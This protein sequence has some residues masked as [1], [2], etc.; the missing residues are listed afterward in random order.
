MFVCSDEEWKTLRS[1]MTT[2]FTGA[3]MKD[4]FKF[5]DKCARQSIQHLEKQ[6]RNRSGKGKPEGSTKPNVS[7]LIFCF[8]GFQMTQT[9]WNW[10]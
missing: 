9:F 4:M 7:N 6:I 2:V 5:M 1:V 8:C 3:K 10:N